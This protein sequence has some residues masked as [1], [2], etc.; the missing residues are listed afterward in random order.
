MVCTN[1]RDSVTVTSN[2]CPFKECQAVMTS[3]LKAKSDD[4][5]MRRNET[6]YRRRGKAVLLM[7]SLLMITAVIVT[8]TGYLS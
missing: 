5:K 2:L 7:S 3:A 8:V 4:H 6:R 1:D